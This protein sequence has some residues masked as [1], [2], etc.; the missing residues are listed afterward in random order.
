MLLGVPQGP[1]GEGNGNPLQC[2]C[3]E[4]PRDGGAWWAAVYGVAW[5]QTRLRQLS[6]SSSSRVLRPDGPTTQG[7]L[8]RAVYLRLPKIHTEV[9]TM[10]PSGGFSAP[11]RTDAGTALPPPPGTG[12]ALPRASPGP[13]PDPGS[14]GSDVSP[15]PRAV[16]GSPPPSHSHKKFS[17]ENT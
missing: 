12:G 17:S 4:N 2:C 6:S 10:G 7:H 1:P 15:I 8:F 13:D 3:L 16:S 9:V 11:R 14:Q 5:S